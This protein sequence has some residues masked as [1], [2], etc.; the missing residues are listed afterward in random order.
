MRRLMLGL[1][2]V[3]VVLVMG[4]ELLLGLIHVVAQLPAL[5]GAAAAVVWAV[6]WRTILAI[7]IPLALGA[8]LYGL[9]EVSFPRRA[10]VVMRRLATRK[11]DKPRLRW[12]WRRRHTWVLA[13]KMPF[14]VTAG[15]IQQER[16]S[17]EQRLDCA[18]RVWYDRG[19]VWMEAG[20][21]A[22]PETVA[23]H[24]FYRARRPDG[25]LVFGVGMGRSGRVWADLAKLPHLLVGGMSGRG[26]SVFLRQFL[27]GL[28]ETHG[29]DEMRTVLFDF[30][31]GI[32]MR[33]FGS[34][35]H[36]WHPVVS[37]LDDAEIAL[38][39]LDAELNRR[40]R[41][42]ERAGVVD[43]AAWNAK[44]L[45]AP[46]P[47]IVVVVDEFAEMSVIEGADADARK[48]RHSLQ[49]SFSRL[50]RLGRA[51][52]IHVVVCTQRPDRDAV[53]GQIKAN[54]QATIAFYVRNTINS[55][56]LLGG[57]AAASLPPWPGRGIWQSDG[58]THV[59]V[60]YIEMEEAER[61]LTH[62]APPPA[63]APTREV[64]T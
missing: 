63:P 49:A 44:H 52:G 36:L 40:Q 31:S 14:G 7:G 29:P 16:E 46:W 60:P 55:E 39:R 15:K 17:I 33:L 51:P 32:E 30:K 37:D 35:G 21:R 50:L 28:I 48:Q 6:A 57:P 12:I 58:E 26:K 45:G 41:E 2:L 11:E 27:T 38:G 25:A 22:I 24:S 19:M 56:I 1:V 4:V 3:P 13:W 8:F 20:T 61:R 9:W 42:I 53:P 43:I 18:V 34:L 59:Q 54:I 23:Y 64:A 47:R 10:T 62:M 5:L